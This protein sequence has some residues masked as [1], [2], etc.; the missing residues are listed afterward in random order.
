MK[1]G[2]LK[3][4]KILGI[5]L[6]Y[7]LSLLPVIIFG[8][9]KN[10]IVPVQKGVIPFWFGTQYFVIPIVVL[11]LSYVFEIYY[12]TVIKK[13]EGM[14][15]VYNSID[16]FVNVLC[17]LVTGPMHKLYITIPIM[18][19][20]DVL[21]KFIDNKVTVNQVALYKC[22]LVGILA[23]MGVKS[24][25]NLYELE[26]VDAVT[27]PSLL[28]IGKGI[29][30]IGTTSTLCALIGYLILIFNKYYKKEMPLI[31]FLGYVVVASILYFAG[32]IGFYDIL[33]NLFNSGFI[34]AIVFVLSLSNATPVVRT[35][36]VLYAF[37]IGL[38]C[39]V[40]VNVSHSF[41]AIYI[42][43]LVASLLVPLFNKFKFTVGK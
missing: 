41:I 12:Y 8:Y 31:A 24:Y 42:T 37:I 1:K 11:F 36:R 20:V 9:Y 6:F 21:L 29:G 22:I 7:L 38:L 4:N 18:V 13:E 39:G 33:R 5:N 34:F 26:L 3:D 23:L 2:F 32:K 30:A 25:A 40:F 27:K 10:G 16:P 43:I 14:S 17:Y 19:V 15:S 28:F 35:G